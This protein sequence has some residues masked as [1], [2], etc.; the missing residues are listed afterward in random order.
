MRRSASHFVRTGLGDVAALPLYR[1]FSPSRQALT[2]TRTMN[3]ALAC[4][5][6]T[7]VDTDQV[8]P[9]GSLTPPLRSGLPSRACGSCTENA[10]GGQRAPISRIDVRDVDMQPGRKRRPGAA[11]VGDH[12]DGVVDSYL[13]VHDGSVGI[14]VSTQLGSAERLFEEVDDL[15]G[16]V[17]HQVGRLV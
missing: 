12:D 2:R 9:P 13:R 3:S 8:F 5:H 11:A 6:A 15:L 7:W 17:D 14:V 10:S 1:T 4:R 16:A